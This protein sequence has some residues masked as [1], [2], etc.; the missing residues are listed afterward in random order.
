MSTRDTRPKW[1][2]E[3]QRRISQRRLGKYGVRA[4]KL[5]PPSWWA[6][7]GEAAA[8]MRLDP[9]SWEDWQSWPNEPRPID[10]GGDLL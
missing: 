5:D 7:I 6:Q 4:D 2:L 8:D 10:D 1:L 3:K 9:G